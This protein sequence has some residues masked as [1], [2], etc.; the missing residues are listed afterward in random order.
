MG[1]EEVFVGVPNEGKISLSL[2]LVKKWEPKKINKI[3]DT[4]FFSVNDMY[5]SMEI[6]KF[7]EIF[8]L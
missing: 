7:N 6:I 2:E 1:K 5:F 8:N 4:V 3:G